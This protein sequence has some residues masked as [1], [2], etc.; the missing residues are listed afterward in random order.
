MLLACLKKVAKGFLS[1]T[2]INELSMVLG[3]VKGGNHFIIRVLWLKNIINAQGKIILIG[4]FPDYSGENCH[5]FLAYPFRSNLCPQ[6]DMCACAYIYPPTSS[7]SSLNG[8]VHTAPNLAFLLVIFPGDDFIQ[9]Y[10]FIHPTSWT[11]HNLSNYFSTSRHLSIFQSFA[12]INN[13]FTSIFICFCAKVKY[14]EDKFQ[15][16]KMLNSRVCAF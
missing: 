8:N 11:D 7:P 9:T 13:A 12:T 14:M 1:N 3:I 6:A 15:E 4:S 5:Q 2:I 10:K 16:V